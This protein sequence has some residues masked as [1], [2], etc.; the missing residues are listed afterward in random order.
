LLLTI[1]EDQTASVTIPKF[2]QLVIMDHKYNQ[3][4]HSV[5]PVAS[6]AGEPRIILVGFLQS[7]SN[8]N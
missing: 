5:T 1:N 4:P 7:G 3:V 6:F 2:N 8:S